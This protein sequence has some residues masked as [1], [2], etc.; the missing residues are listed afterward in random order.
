MDINQLEV[1][2]NTAREHAAG[3]LYTWHGGRSAVAD[4][5]IIELAI[6]LEW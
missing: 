1:F 4:I 6:R 3:L 5:S 2:V